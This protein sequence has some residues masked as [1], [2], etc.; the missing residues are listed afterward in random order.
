MR[1]RVITRGMRGLLSVPE[2]L[3]PFRSGWI[4]IQLLSHNVLRWFVPILLVMLLVGSVN[5]WSHPLWRWASVLQA[6][7]Y[8]FAALS[9]YLR[10]HRLWK[11]FSIPVYFC[12]VNL[13]AL[14]SLVDLIRGRR[15][16]TW[17]TV[18]S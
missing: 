4:A 13:A 12:T 10:L 5:L 14:R 2:L 15:Y 1:V 17:Q 16:V 7:F 9:A 8:G 18:R 3:N 6:A 11:P